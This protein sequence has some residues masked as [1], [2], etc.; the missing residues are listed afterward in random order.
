MIAG[1]YSLDREIGRGGMGAVWLGRDETLGRAVALKRVGVPPGGD[2]PDH[3]RAEREAKMAAKLSHPHVVSVYDLVPDGELMWLVMEYVEGTNLA[4]LIRANG[5]LPV[6]QAAPILAQ[7]AD[8]LAAAHEVGV[9]HRD[10]KPSNILVTPEGQ[11]KLSDFGIARAIGDP[12]LTQ[13]GLVTGSPAYLAPEVASGGS[14]TAMSDIWSL[15]ATAYHAIQGHPPYDVG[16]NLLGALYRIVHEDPPRPSTPGW[17]LPLFEATMTREEG[18]RW[19]AEEV[20]RF[21]VAG[22]GAVPTTR[23]RRPRATTAAAVG[24]DAGTQVLRPVGTQT[25]ES[26][27]V[28][29]GPAPDPAYD[30]GPRPHRRRGRVGWLASLAALIAVAVVGVLLAFVLGDDPATSPADQAAPSPTPS[31][32]SPSPTPGPSAETMDAFIRAYV[33]TAASSQPD[34]FALLTPDYQTASGGLGDYSAFW[35]RVSEPE[36]RSLDADPESLVVTYRYRYRLGGED[37][38]ETVR[39]QLAYA[40]GRYQIAGDV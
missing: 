21:L 15:G 9:V 13:T 29:T 19:D 40:D 39:L 11:V 17:L 14:A 20:R 37:V 32:S 25:R 31:S 38:N 34:G 27:V 3:E 22:P 24:A 18:Q 36:I 33:V 5:S 26:P 23:I 7:T 6:D 10:I 30:D 16:D 8:A 12:A 28:P 35:G 2:N 1:R 4:E